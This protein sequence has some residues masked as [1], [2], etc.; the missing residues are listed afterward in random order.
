[1]RPRQPR[2]PTPDALPAHEVAA[3]ATALGVPLEPA[4]A[5]QLS[6]FAA[7]LLKWSAVHNLTALDDGRSVLTHHLLDSLA[8]LPTIDALAAEAGR[9]LRILD[10]GAGGGMPGI[11]IAIARPT[12]SLTLIDKVQ[13]KVAFLRQAQLELELA[14]VEP[15]HARVEVWQ[16][17]PFDIVIARA[18]AS[19]TELIQWTGHLLAPTGHWLAMKGPAYES[20]LDAL[21]PQVLLVRT[22]TLDVPRLHQERYLLVLAPATA[23]ATPPA[24]ARAADS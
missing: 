5:E 9:P 16:A 11:P 4:A 17:P 2:G 19:V 7:L 3:G 10:V 8:V 22:V 21:P 24:P 20:E 13:K 1:M 18:L 6:R 15:V 12:Y 23:P 14:N